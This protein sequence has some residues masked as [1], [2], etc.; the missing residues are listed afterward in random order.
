MAECRCEES[1]FG[2][3][4]IAPNRTNASRHASESGQS[5]SS[6]ASVPWCSRRL[7]NGWDLHMHATCVL[8]AMTRCN[9]TPF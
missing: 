7:P 1:N 5:G 8:T 2:Q 9:E 3:N 4:A 6:G